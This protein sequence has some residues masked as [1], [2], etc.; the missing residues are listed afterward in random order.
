MTKILDESC[1]ELLEGLKASE[2][3]NNYFCTISEKMGMEF[4]VHNLSNTVE[5]SECITPL[6]DDW[7]CILS[8]DAVVEQV[9]KIDTAKASGFAEVNSKLMKESL[10]CLQ[11]AF[12]YIL[13]LSLEQ[14]WFLKCWKSA[15]VIVIPKRGNSKLVSNLRPISLLPITGKNYGTFL[16]QLPC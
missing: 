8:V 7:P 15:T 16:K 12:T 3:V 14:C 2:Y 9:K 10:L 5:H 4:S 13:N 1:G 11:E 6:N